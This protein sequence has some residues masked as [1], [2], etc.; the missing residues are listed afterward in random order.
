MKVLPEWAIALGAAATIV[1]ATIGATWWVGRAIRRLWRWGT[2]LARRLE[3]LADLAEAELTANGGGSMLD[4][5]NRIPALD[6]RLDEHI[7]DT[8]TNFKAVQMQIVDLSNTVASM[9]A[10][11]K[12]PPAGGVE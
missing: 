1:S 11:L 4:K 7:V 9:D 6:R 5:V 10:R 3:A 2:Y 8:G 12:M